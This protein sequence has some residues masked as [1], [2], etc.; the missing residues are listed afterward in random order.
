MEGNRF[1]LQEDLISS[2]CELYELLLCPALFWCFLKGAESMNKK[3]KLAVVLILALALCAF[4][5]S[6]THSF[7]KFHKWQIPGYFKGFNVSEWSNLEEQPVSQQ[8]FLDLKASGAN[9]AVIQTRGTVLDSFP[10]GPNIY[11]SDQY[12]TVY[13]QDVLDT[14]VTYARNSEMQYV[15]TIRTGPGRRDVAEEPYL[16]R[17]STVWTNPTEQKLYGQMLKDICQRYLPDTLLV[18]IDMTVEPN[19]YGE[20]AAGVPVEMLDSA[21]TADGI[22][23]NALYTVWIDSVRTV[24]P[25]LP[26]MVEGVHWS[27]P[28]YYSLVEKQLDNK[29]V[30]KVHCYNP[31]EYSHADSAFSLSYPGNYW[32]IAT[33]A[34]ALYNKDFLKNTEYGAVRTFQQAHDV[35]ILIGEFGIALPQQG[36]EQYLN[37]IMTIADEFGWHFSLWNWNNAAEFN[38]RHFDQTHGTNYMPMISEFFTGATDVVQQA[39]LSASG[40]KECILFQNYPN[41]CNPQTTICYQL[42]APCR[43]ELA[44]YN[45]TGQR[46]RTLVHSDQPAGQFRI[47]WD[48][49]NDWGIL[50]SA[51][52]YFCNLKAG[53]SRPLSRKIILL[54]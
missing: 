35:P 32:S 13:W 50:V 53:G 51:G 41:P 46:I 37:D 21:M 23:V 9:L 44:I 26:L 45:I 38:Y 20:L 47:R 29:I 7:S 25:D 14:M 27:N 12:D 34:D 19:P 17:P 31:A 8:D 43:V 39:D 54:K 30:Y 4:G 11:Y 42:P 16:G 5:G 2:N 24:A 18:G 15:I 40:I 48:G 6:K 33:Q 22:N 3:D 52:I 28:V 1:F 36:G 10:Y 49:T